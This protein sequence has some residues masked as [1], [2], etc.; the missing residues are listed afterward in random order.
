MIPFKVCLNN[1]VE[2]LNINDKTITAN[3][4]VKTCDESALAREIAHENPLVPEQ[5]ACSVLENVC[6]AAVNLMSMGFAIQ[7]RCGNDVMLRIHPDIHVKGGSINLAR[8]QQIDPTVTELTLEN[9]GDLVARTGVTVRVKAEC[10]PRFSEMLLA[11][12]VS[13]QRSAV[14]ERAFIPRVTDND[15]Q[16]VTP[17]T[18]DNPGGGDTPGGDNGGGNDNPGGDDNGGDLGE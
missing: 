12:G 10:A 7:L 3:E 8:A 4:D 18:P 6:K 11:Q 5:I 2:A 16:P 15:E 14:V 17:N 1:G 9:A 13:V